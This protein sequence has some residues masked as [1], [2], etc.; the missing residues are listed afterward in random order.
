M[1]TVPCSK[2]NSSASF[3]NHF[4]RISAIA[5]SELIVGAV[6]KG[7]NGGRDKRIRLRA[8]FSDDIP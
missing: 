3:V 1:S 4:S 8:L 6:E 2:V 5:T 7:V